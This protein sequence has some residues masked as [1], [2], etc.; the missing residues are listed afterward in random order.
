M[1]IKFSAALLLVFSFVLTFVSCGGDGKTEDGGKDE[2]AEVIFSKS[3]AVS[4]VKPD[5]E[6]DFD[7][8]AVSDKIYELTGKFAPSIPESNAPA[9]H[10]IV[11]GDTSR[12]ISSVAKEKLVRVILNKEREAEDNGVISAELDGYLAYSDGK[13][14]AVVWSDPVIARFAVSNFV[15]EF[16]TS[17]TLSL[18]DGYVYSDINELISYKKVYEAKEREEMFSEIETQLGVE[19][20]AALKKYYSLFDERYYT[21]MA[22]LYDPGEYDSEG[23]P[24]GGGYY[25]SN[26][27]RDNVG[28]GI[29]LESTAQALTLLSASGMLR[30][31]SENGEPDWMAAIPEK[32]QREI[33]A[34]VK[35]LQSSEDGYFYH[36]QW[37]AVT[38]SRRGRDLDWATS[39][40]ERFGAQPYFDT[41]NG[42]EGE[43]GAPGAVPSSVI[44]GSLSH[45]KAEA[46]SFVLSVSTDPLPRELQSISNFKTYLD[47]FTPSMGTGSYSIGNTLGAIS[48]Q[49]VARGEEYIKAFEEWANALQN[50]ENGLFEDKVHYNSV[51]GLMKMSGTYNTLGIKFNYAEKALESA[52]KMIMH[53][54]EDVKGK[55]A[56]N[57]V[58][59]WNPFCAITNLMDNIGKFGDETKLNAFL[60]RVR[61]NATEL[62]YIT[63]TKTAQFKKP[64]GSF[65]YGNGPVG[66]T[67]QGAPVAV[68]GTIEGDINGGNIAVTGVSNYM[69][70]V[71]GIDVIPIYYPTDL[72][73]YFKHINALGPVIKDDVV[74]ETAPIDFEEDLVGTSTP[75]K[76]AVQVGS[77]SVTVIEDPRGEGN[78]LKFITKKGVYTAIGT[79][80]AATRSGGCYYLEFDI[81]M[82]EINQTGTFFQIKVGSSYMLTLN[83]NDGKIVI[84][85]SSNTNGQIAVAQKFGT[86]FDI[87]EWA[88]IRIEYYA[89]DLEEDVRVKI[90][91]NDDLIAI[92][93]NYYGH[94]TSGVGEPVRDFGTVEFYALNGSDMTVL[95]DNILAK[96]AD[97]NFDLS[98]G[99]AEVKWFVTNSEYEN[100]FGSVGTGKYAE[101]D[102]TLRYD[103]AEYNGLLGESAS[104]EIISEGKNKILS[105]KKTGAE[106]AIASFVKYKM[107]GPVYVAETDIKWRGQKSATGDTLFALSLVSAKDSHGFVDVF[108]DLTEDGAEL[109]LFGGEGFASLSDNKWYN[110]RIEV[111]PS[112]TDSHLFTLKVFLDSACVLEKSLTVSEGASIEQYYGFIIKLCEGAEGYSIDLDNTYSGVAVTTAHPDVKYNYSNPFGFDSSIDGD[113]VTEKSTSASSV[114]RIFTLADDPTGA[115]NRVLKA[116][117]PKDSASEYSG[118]TVIKNSSGNTGADAVYSSLSAKV[119]FETNGD[120]AGDRVARLIFKDTTYAFGLD[121]FVSYNAGSGEYS[122]RITHYNVGTNGKGSMDTIVDGVKVINKWFDLRIDYCKCGTSSVLSIYIDGT[123]YAE[124]V[125]GYYYGDRITNPGAVGEVEWRYIRSG[126]TTYLDDVVYE[127]QVG[128]A[129]LDEGE[130]EP[131]APDTPPTDPDDPEGGMGGTEN[132]DND[133]SDKESSMPDEGWVEKEEP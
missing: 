67:S 77:G 56:V 43:F 37:E 17:D 52:L 23:N 95:F 3:V 9:E 102:K 132:P 79:S 57:S 22:N 111:I 125:V 122:L 27:G 6:T 65:G 116:F 60:S 97:K 123:C 7:T 114:D 40:L 107:Q 55:A 110:L 86:Y 20:T 104:S 35:S 92:S 24:T 11:F 119:Y 49:I 89:A 71:L 46:V 126:I 66:A 80:P 73:I 90:Y 130:D 131:V 64:D 118:Y 120:T 68:G 59:V 25:F 14:V 1:K 38:V 124:D 42:Y 84:G 85:D 58:D 50:P 31:Y 70:R 75:N 34:F 127:C 72:E 54:G 133:G 41:P 32:M 101:S 69:C 12:P 87:R 109:R 26:S 8:G 15:L 51:N 103:D 74:L 13:S 105:I 48:S 99:N 121:V 21:W 115:V 88:N 113:F 4:I 33:V 30:E 93:D 61:E 83:Y 98:D 39:L 45:S 44:S 117:Y 2:P 47:S 94:P 28:Y 53:E 91:V 81:C 129:E 96:R 78:V 19:A 18:K 10:E 106:S 128:S 62:I 5:G 36:P 29:D 100:V 112:F 108:A 82:E 16:L 63:L 76:I